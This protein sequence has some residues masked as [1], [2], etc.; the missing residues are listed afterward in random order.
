MVQK[1]VPGPGDDF[2]YKNEPVSNWPGIWRF[3][4]KQ[5]PM[6]LPLVIED[7]SLKDCLFAVRLLLARLEKN[8]R[9]DDR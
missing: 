3:A 7:N 1:L 6:F 5:S 8:V 2:D 9:E 4:R